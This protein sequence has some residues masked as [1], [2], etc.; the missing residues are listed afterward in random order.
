M[1]RTSRICLF[2][3]QNNLH[4]KIWQLMINLQNFTI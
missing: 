1:I 4:A 2:C 3:N